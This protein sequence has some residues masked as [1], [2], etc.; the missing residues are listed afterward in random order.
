[1][2]LIRREKDYLVTD[3]IGFSALSVPIPTI[4]ALAIHLERSVRTV[5][6]DLIIDCLRSADSFVL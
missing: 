1:M 2:S 5:G 3:G 4:V 6:S